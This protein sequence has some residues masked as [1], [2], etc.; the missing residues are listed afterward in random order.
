M[1]H[2]ETDNIPAFRGEAALEFSLIHALKCDTQLQQW[3]QPSLWDSHA[4]FISDVSTFK[5]YSI[6]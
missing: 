6:S 2:G 4:P 1:W 5:I 3:R